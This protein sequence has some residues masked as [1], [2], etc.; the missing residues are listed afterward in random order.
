[1]T[2]PSSPATPL[3]PAA[4][5]SRLE[6]R[7]VALWLDEAGRLR[8]RAP[9]GTITPAVAARIKEARPRL[10]PLLRERAPFDALA[11]PLAGLDLPEE[12]AADYPPHGPR[13]TEA[14]AALLREAARGNLP[15]APGC[16]QD[17]NTLVPAL[18][19]RFRAAH[20][21]DD[22]DAAEAASS[23]LLDWAEWWHAIEE[24]I[25]P[26]FYDAADPNAPRINW[27]DPARDGLTYAEAA[28]RFAPGIRAGLVE[29]GASPELRAE[30][31]RAFA[32]PPARE[33]EPNR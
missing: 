30:A 4:F 2:T 15:P 9:A 23:A 12:V 3:D 24:R 17:P 5:L 22:N 19:A 13:T 6:G 1:M 27:H 26:P 7:G 18:H 28:A 20:A 8:Y 25:G 21:A 33:K 16:D 32:E 10:L 31:G 29:A 11:D 14:A